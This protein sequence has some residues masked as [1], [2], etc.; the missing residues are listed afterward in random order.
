MKKRGRFILHMKKQDYEALTR[1]NKFKRLVKVALL[2]L[3]IA[4]VV[5]AP[6][7]WL[8]DASV[9]MRAALRSA[10]NV[11][12]NTELLAIKFDGVD[13]T[14]LDSSRSSGLSAEAE[15]EIRNFSGA[16]GEIYLASW[17]PI[18]GHILNMAYREGS[19]L[20]TYEYDEQEDSGRWEIFRS[21]RVYEN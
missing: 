5:L 16:D 4:A 2:T 21:V 7:L 12:L 20:V 17:D 9:K 10:K 6:T 11:V 18:S 15:D 3:L 8:W 14:L 1:V 19:F 13:V